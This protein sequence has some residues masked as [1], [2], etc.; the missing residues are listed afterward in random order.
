M[1]CTSRASFALAV[2]AQGTVEGGGRR[3]HVGDWSGVPLIGVS[4][5]IGFDLH[6]VR[7]LTIALGVPAAA[8]AA[9]A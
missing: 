2:W 5:T 3:E 4:H 9:A 1:E 8:T 6:H 7:A